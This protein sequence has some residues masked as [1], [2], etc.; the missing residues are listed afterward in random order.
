MTYSMVLRPA[1]AENGIDLKTAFR[2]CHRFLEVINNDQAGEL[3]G[4]T[5]LDETFFRESFKG[6]REGLPRPTPKAW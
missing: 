5:E 3:C 1:A 6:Q 4:I 2:W